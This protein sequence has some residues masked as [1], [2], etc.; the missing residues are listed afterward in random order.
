MCS[1]RIT[2][3]QEIYITIPQ[4]ET[5]SG[6]VLCIIPKRIKTNINIINVP[7]ITTVLSYVMNP[8]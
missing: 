3:A 2:H 7:N 5:Y 4:H 8:S 6:I 1:G